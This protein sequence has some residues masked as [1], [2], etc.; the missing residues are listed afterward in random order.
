M[1]ERMQDPEVAVEAAIKE[2]KANRQATLTQ[3]EAK[4]RELNF[5]KNGPE[6]PDELAAQM[7]E[8]LTC[9]MDRLFEEVGK[10]VPTTMH[11]KSVRQPIFNHDDNKLLTL[12]LRRILDG[13]LE[14]F[15]EQELGEYKH[16]LPA[17]ERPAR[18]AE[19]QA[20]LDALKALSDSLVERLQALSI[21][22]SLTLTREQRINQRFV[23][24]LA[25]SRGGR[26]RYIE[27][28]G[29]ME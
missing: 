26:S 22:G 21:E 20:E 6:P 3:I 13:E 4:E 14:R 7:R 11:R 2:L 10:H 24:N 8:W 28:G 18:V 16:S 25:R 9:H 1:N 29:R 15:I 12:L 23:E 27:S 19:L 5:L 17:S